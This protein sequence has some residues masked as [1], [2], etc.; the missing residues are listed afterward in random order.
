MKDKN[1]LIIDD[2]L[3]FSDM[4]SEILRDEGAQVFVAHDGAQGYE[5]AQEIHPDLIMCDMMMP[6][7]PGIDVLRAV[8]A[9]AW[10]ANVPFLFLTNMNQADM[11]VEAKALGGHTECLLKTDWTLDQLTE[12]VK[13]TLAAQG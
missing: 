4:I 6:R 7:M 11:L 12:K 5:T 8:R 10:G 3:A 1:I 2:D 13:N 9:T